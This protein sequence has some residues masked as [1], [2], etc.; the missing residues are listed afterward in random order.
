MSQMKNVLVTGGAGYIGSHTAKA[1]SNAGHQPI[2]FDN[3]STGHEW[4]VKWG[5][6]VRGDLNDKE[7]IVRTFRE[8]DIDAVIHFA[9]SAYVG[10]SVIH[11]RHY[12]QNNIANSLNLLDAMLDAGVGQIVFSSS[13]ATYG[14]PQALP[15]AEDH[16]Q[17]PLSP[18]GDSKYFVE[19]AMDA[20]RQAYGLKYV[21]LRYFNAAGADPEGELGEVHLP[22]THLIP[23]IIEVA[24]G[25]RAEIRLF[26][27]DY[28]THDGTCVRDFI[29]VSDLARAHVLALEY[30]LGGNDC[31]AF[32][33]GT[34][35]GH[36]VRE[37]LAVVEGVSDHTI[38]VQTESRRPG[39]AASL[40]ADPSRAMQVLGWT[41]EF[42]SL[43]RIVSDAWAWHLGLQ[44]RQPRPLFNADRQSLSAY[45]PI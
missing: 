22:E 32:N 26:G 23:S 10:D 21:S 43:E 45:S 8:F 6:L 28:D 12:F 33:L 20:Y 13:C 4:A 5:P 37:V 9:A 35:T 38:Q 18:Y 3:L 17:N 41:P 2:T 44:N 19:R 25:T 24:L 11:P 34:G 15:I 31:A 1:L 36:S 40:V 30:V 39:D 27:T 16:P 7:L 42:P 29:H 14:D